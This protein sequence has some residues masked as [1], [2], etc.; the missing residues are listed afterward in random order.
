MNHWK[1]L[2]NLI[3]FKILII[4]AL[5]YCS[6]AFAQQL[7]PF[8]VHYQVFRNGTHMA[9][10][11]YKLSNRHGLWTWRMEMQPRGLYQLFTRKKPFTETQALI[12]ENGLKLISETAGDY[13]N[14]PARKASWIDHD[15]LRIYY[16]SDKGQNKLAF[17]G[18]LY[19][20][21]TIHLLTS[22][23]KQAQNDAVQ[24]SLYHQ[25]KIQ[26]AGIDYQ[27]DISETFKNISISGNQITV[28][29]DNSGKSMKYLYDETSL[30]PL[31]IEQQNKDDEKIV[32]IRQ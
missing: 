22:G 5:V 29:L 21:D 9:D 4:P 25:G 20:H 18:D 14:R 31:K 24:T 3:S 32:M 26:E 30:A 7:E 8:D 10:A 13:Q 19:N 23:F 6:N 1:S 15:Q 28:R 27:L 17:S 2:C 16:A 12:T 11:S